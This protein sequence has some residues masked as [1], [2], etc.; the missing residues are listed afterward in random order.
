MQNYSFKCI[1]NQ[2]LNYIFNDI[3]ANFNA[4]NYFNF[5]NTTFY[6]C[7]TCEFHS[8]IFD[9]GDYKKLYIRENLISIDPAVQFMLH[10][11]RE[12]LFFDEVNYFEAI[13][14][15]GE[16]YYPGK[17]I[18]AIKASSQFNMKNG[19]YTFMH[20]NSNYILGNSYA[21]DSIKLKIDKFLDKKY[22]EGKWFSEFTKNLS[23]LT[24]NAIKE[25]EK[26][27]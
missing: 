25:Y 21:Y 1:K 5:I 18:N 19:F 2:R 23:F 20:L 3:C 27:I 16:I 24:L 13:N 12:I 9:P 26:K 7:N 4:K 6:N 8:I 17:I 22:T 15:K 11:R 10:S 14:K